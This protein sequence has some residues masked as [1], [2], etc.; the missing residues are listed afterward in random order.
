MWQRCVSP[1]PAHARAL[2]FAG[3]RS[4][5]ATFGAGATSSPPTMVSKVFVA[6]GAGRTG[7]R[8]VRA[9]ATRGISVRVGCRDV[10][11]A[12]KTVEGTSG[13]FA[14]SALLTYVPVDVVERPEG[15]RAAIGDADAVVSALGATSASNPALPYKVDSVGTSAL[16]QAAAETGNVEHA[17]MVSSLG[18]EKVKFPAALLNLFWGIL[19]WKRQ[20]EV[21][22]VK[23]GIPYTIVRPGGLEAAGDDYGD[24]HNVVLGSANAFGGGTVS[25][26]QVAD[27]VA[28]ALINPDVSANKVV[29]IIAKDDVPKR[30]IKDLLATL[31]VYSV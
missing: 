19:L 17:V 30:P 3:T 23:S 20:A 9:L 8:V 10:E 29:E 1:R 7:A 16:F 22:L 31:P 6:G 11:A 24:T 28:E 4:R 13:T 12:R 25:R 26:M 2:P 5:R 15:L 18:T 14:Q 21:A 27:V